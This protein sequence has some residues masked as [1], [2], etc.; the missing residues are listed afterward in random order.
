V[1]GKCRLIALK[2]REYLSPLRPALPAL[3]LRLS[4]KV[5]CDSLFEVFV[6]HLPVRTADQ[7]MIANLASVNSEQWRGEMLLQ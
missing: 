1:R 7:E 4:D 6:R 2:A 5:D 3:F